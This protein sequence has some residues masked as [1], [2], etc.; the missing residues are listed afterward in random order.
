M[1]R[2]FSKLSIVGAH[3]RQL[4]EDDALVVFWFLTVAFGARRIQPPQISRLSI[5]L[6]VPS[7][8]AA[9]TTSGAPCARSPA[10]GTC[11]SDCLRTEM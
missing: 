1:L 3:A 8:A 4:W 10:D 5:N 2:H 6:V 7:F 11:R 9:S